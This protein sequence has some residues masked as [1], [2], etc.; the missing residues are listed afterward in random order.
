MA[1]QINI[2]TYKTPQAKMYK[3]NATYHVQNNII[4]QI[5]ISTFTPIT[6]SLYMAITR[7]INSKRTWGK[8]Y[9]AVAYDDAAAFFNY[10]KCRS[11]GNFFPLRYS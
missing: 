1:H 8:Q 2:T 9:R 4:L 10:L 5:S 3:A 11:C 7:E 6:S